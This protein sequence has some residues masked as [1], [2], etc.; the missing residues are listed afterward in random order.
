MQFLEDSHGCSGWNGEMAGRIRAFDWSLTELG[1]LDSWSRSLSSA[2]RL[3]LASPLPMVMLWGQSGY[4]IYNDAYSKFA[5]GRH[6][7]LLG[8]SVELGWPEVAEF[9]RH[10]VD[11]CLAGGTLSYRNKELVLLRDGVPEDVWMD[12]YYSPVADDDGRPAGVMSMVVE[13]TERVI[14]EQRRQVAE[15]AYRADNERVRLALN[16]G[17][18][19]GSFVWDIKANVLSGDE[20]Y[21]RTFSYPPGQDLQN[22]SQE[23]AESRIHPD[24]RGWVQERVTLS[25]ETGEPYNVEY[26]I[27]RPDGSYL[28]VLA[29][30]CCEFN[31]QGEAFR[32]PGVLIDIHERKNAEESLLKFTRNLEQRVAD[33]V[34]ARL[35]AEEQLRQSQKLEAIGGLTGG[36]AHDFNNLLQ[37]IAGNLHLLAR[38]EPGNANVQRRVSASIAAVE[39]GAKLSSQLL[40][41]ARRQPLSPAVFTLRQIFDGLAELLLRALG[42]TLQVHMTAPEDA[43]NVFV[44]R[45]QLENAIL[46]LA[47]NARDA[48]QGE[49]RIDLCAEN[50]VLDHK[51]CAAKG[52]LPGDYVRVSV[53]DTGVGM[54]PQ[55]LAQAFEPFFTTKADGQGTGLGLSMVFGFVKQSGGHIEIASD[56]GQGTRVQLYFPR[57]LRSA[58]S[59]TPNPDVPQR[60]GHE[61]ILVVEDNEAVR[62]SAVELL[63]E[64]GYQVLTATNGDVAMQMLLEGLA[65]DLIFTDVVMPGLIKSS[66][67]AAWAKVQDPP[68]AVLF[69]SGHTRD[70]IS[71]NH[72]LSPDT[73]LLSKPY[74]PEALRQMVRMV[75]N[76]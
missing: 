14:S 13:T 37:V 52:I 10:V 27:Q 49:G 38:H 43:W 17:A 70:I 75:L 23:I 69:T 72:Q 9:N 6:P 32:F 46:N 5:G 36:V 44:D 18:L 60:G 16:A 71:R 26:R 28:W 4:M 56:V 39:R 62:V 59:E 8:S 73:H 48:L 40:A 53:T 66:D 19:L 21:A 3:M 42:E 61:C 67:L 68:V 2:V 74:N 29:S 24:D 30:G 58:P 54:P 50:I 35:A 45:N 64:E 12:L 34:E 22:L 51:F 41:F 33:E 63:R 7:Y 65:V 25:V 47:I 31:E 11:T 20:R 57:T 76:G 15:D 55:V 1:P